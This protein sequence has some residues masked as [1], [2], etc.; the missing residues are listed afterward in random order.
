MSGVESG[1]KQN[2]RKLTEAG[3]SMSMHWV[4]WSLRG[5]KSEINQGKKTHDKQHINTSHIVYIS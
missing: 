1:T 2:N 5:H 4:S 3:S